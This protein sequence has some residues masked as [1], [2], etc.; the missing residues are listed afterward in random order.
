MAKKHTTD[1]TNGPIFMKFIKFAVPLMISS[2]FQQL[3]HSADLFVAG[4]FSRDCATT[5]GAVGACGSITTLI[6]NMFVGLS[7]GATVV[8]ANHFGAGNQEKLNRS[9]RTAIAFAFCGGI[10]VAILGNFLARPL[11]MLLETPGEILDRAVS[12][13]RIIFIGKLPALLYNS[14]A[15]ILR[16][17]GDTKRPMYIL[18]VSGLINLSLNLVFVICFHWDEVGVAVATMISQI[19]SASVVLSIIFHPENGFGVKL[20]DI[21]IFKE[22]FIG[23]LKVGIPTGLNST[24]FSVAN[25]TVTSALNSLGAK[26]VA[27]IAAC[28]S[29]TN[30]INTIGGSMGTASVSFAAQN[31]GAGKL[32]RV[33]RMLWQAILF[34]DSVYLILALIVTPNP[35]FFVGIFA[36]DPEIIPYGVEK[37]LLFAWGVM[38]NAPQ[39]MFSACQRGM[40]ETVVP[41]IV[42]LAFTVLPRLFWILFVFPNLPQKATWIYISFPISWGLASVAQFVSYRKTRKRAEKRVSEGKM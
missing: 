37:L 2:L 9:V 3:Y 41:T 21:R 26:A 40:R 13:I 17:F 38:L 22:E 39:Q 15:G 35:S 27:G 10:F 20:K 7:A 34:A 23:I 4:N 12:Y 24:L 42:S 28:N 6:L 32:K 18:T 1:L 11:L 8:C 36:N 25:V 30:I 31:Y 14:G 29:V 19:V 5:L 33:D 16:A